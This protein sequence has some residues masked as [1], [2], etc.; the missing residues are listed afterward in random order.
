MAYAPHRLQLRNRS[1]IYLSL[2]LPH[3]PSDALTSEPNA[4]LIGVE[5]DLIGLLF[6]GLAA[7]SSVSY[8]SFD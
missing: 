3:A 2:G 1:L 8:G 7:I 5:L 6:C 4:D